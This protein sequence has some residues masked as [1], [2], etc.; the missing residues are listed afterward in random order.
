MEILK[1]I[2]M[3]RVN[4]VCGFLSQFSAN[5]HEILYT[6]LCEIGGHLGRNLEFIKGHRV[7]FWGLLVC[8][9]CGG[10]FS[11]HSLKFSAWYEFVQ[12]RILILLA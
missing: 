12:V 7:N 8:C 11:K 9:T 3:T 10:S 2:S 6:L 4:E 1:A 5:F